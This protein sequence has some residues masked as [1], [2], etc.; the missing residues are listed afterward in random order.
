MTEQIK[1]NTN[2]NGKLHCNVMVHISSAPLTC[3]P[4]SAVMRNVIEIITIDRSY[5]PTNWKLLDLCRL[6]LGN[7][8]N[9][10]TYASHGLDFYDFYQ[11]YKS[12]YPSAN[13]A[14]PMAVYFYKKIK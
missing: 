12:I 5:P 9:C 3:Y 11:Q 7:L 1:F 10:F 8:Q 13:A 4:E 2:I 6:P 14:T